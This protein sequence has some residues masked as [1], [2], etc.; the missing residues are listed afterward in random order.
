MKAIFFTRFGFETPDGRSC[1]GSF[2]F[3]EFGNEGPRI[4]RNQSIY[5]AHFCKIPQIS[6]RARISN[7]DSV[8]KV[9]GKI[10]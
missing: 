9:V 4:Y 5:H 7:L 3:D 6:S 8:S 10:G 1:E 2:Q